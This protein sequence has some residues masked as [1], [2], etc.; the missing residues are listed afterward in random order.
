MKVMHIKEVKFTVISKD[1]K[2]PARIYKDKTTC[3]K[4]EGRMIW[5]FKEDGCS[6][7]YINEDCIESISVDVELDEEVK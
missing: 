2:Q 7:D 4:R 5:F 3:I 1:G 6:R